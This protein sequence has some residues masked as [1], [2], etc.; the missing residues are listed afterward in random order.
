MLFLQV[1][2]LRLTV[3]LS[4]S[5]EKVMK[6]KLAVWDRQGTLGIFLVCY[7]KS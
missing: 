3:K 6:E 7:W 1:S 2:L 4:S 5:R